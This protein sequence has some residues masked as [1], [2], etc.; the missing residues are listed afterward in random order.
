[1][2][3][4]LGG[5]VALITGGNS[6][7]GEA[8]C[9]RLA[10]EGAS[11]LLLARRKKEGIRV[12]DA[13]KKAGGEATFVPCDV[14]D[15]E[16]VEVTVDKAAKIYGPIHILFNNAGG[17]GAGGFPDS[18]TS[19][20]NRVININLNGTFYVSRAVWPHL[21]AAGGGAVVN[22]SSLAAQRGFSPKMHHEFG[23]TAPSY[24]A[25]KAGIEGLTRFMAGVGGDHNI[26]VNAIRPGQIITPGA[27]GGTIND[28]DGGH[29]I[30]EK[31]F[32]V[33]QIVPGPGYPQDVANLILFLVSED[34]RFITGEMINIDGGVAAKI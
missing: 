3:G 24:Y 23:T 13:I 2:P 11:V 29:H 12:Q 10:L 7:I 19:D 1:M 32:D 21:I 20:W 4:K 25:A 18:T 9:H 26:R 31:M 30:F 33:A 28:P 5:K 14:G 34:S 8:T 22:M 15:P 6:G 27:T 17:G 16:S